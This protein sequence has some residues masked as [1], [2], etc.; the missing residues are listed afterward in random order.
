MNSQFLCHSLSAICWHCPQIWESTSRKYPTEKT[1]FVFSHRS[2]F[3]AASGSTLWKTLWF[4]LAWRRISGQKC[5]K[6]C[7]KIGHPTVLF[8]LNCHSLRLPFVKNVCQC[9]TQS[10]LLS[11]GWTFCAAK[12]QLS[13]N[14]CTCNMKVWPKESSIWT[15]WPN[16]CVRWSALCPSC[17]FDL[18]KMKRTKTFSVPLCVCKIA[19]ARV[20]CVQQEQWWIQFQS[21]KGTKGIQSSSMTQVVF[22]E[23][24]YTCRFVLRV[25]LMKA[26]Q[27]WKIRPESMKCGC[28]VGSQLP[29][30]TDLSKTLFSPP[31]RTVYS[32]R[33]LRNFSTTPTSEGQIQP[34]FPKDF[35]DHSEPQKGSA[36]PAINFASR[37]V[38][39]PKY[40]WFVLL[41]LTVGKETVSPFWQRSVFSHCCGTLI[42]KWKVFCVWN[43]LKWDLKHSATGEAKQCSVLLF[44]FGR[45]E[46]HLGNACNFLFYIR[47]AI[48]F[49]QRNLRNTNA[50]AGILFSGESESGTGMPTLCADDLWWSR[51]LLAM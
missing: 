10:G 29:E 46:I 39:N 18:N 5:L 12:E 8:R 14:G 15:V 22:V 48:P 44:L 38:N 27:D 9:W 34:F 26:G 33:A 7:Q 3:K 6:G 50:K 24:R 37:K 47:L 32:C 43:F 31:P 4:C 13:R 23:V 25:S 11:S 2:V 1:L 41:F 28:H 16:N 42:L 20:C 19:C 21:V 45:M 49:G 40:R 30:P 35:F 36:L 17:T 51:T